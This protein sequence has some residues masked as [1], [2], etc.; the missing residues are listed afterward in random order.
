[1]ISADQL[2]NILATIALAELMFLLGLR[3][4]IEQVRNV[5]KDSVLVA[6]A[7]IA[8]YLVVPLLTI[9]LV[10]AFHVKPMIAAGF[11]IAVVCAGAPYG[12]P[13]TAMARGDVP[14]AVGVMVILSVLAA[15]VAPLLLYLLLPIIAGSQSLAVNVLKV[16]LTL[17][18][19]QLL[20]L[21]AGLAIRWRKPESAIKLEVPAKR[22]SVPLNLLFIGVGL[23]A[24]WHTLARISARGY[25]EMFVLAVATVVVGWML[26][27]PDVRTRR[28][29]AADTSVRNVGLGLVIATG[30]FAGTL[31]VSSALV[32]AIFQ[33][34]VLALVF[35]AWGKAIPIGGTTVSTKTALI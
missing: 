15:P 22:L 34:V 32:Y 10:M 2:V 18:L 14:V 9:G 24:Q 20:P 28:A 31:A 12:P 25:L 23:Y 29:I 13:F 30:S 17:L 11:L 5:A 33:T 7:V 19:T 26:G 3:V 35:M 1:M 16:V 27:G 21:C 4:K 8:S 6:K